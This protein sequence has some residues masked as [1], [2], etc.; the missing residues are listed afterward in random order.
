MI[1]RHGKSRSEKTEHP[2]TSDNCTERAGK[3]KWFDSHA[4]YKTLHENWFCH[5]TLCDDFFRGYQLK[6]LVAELKLLS[7]V[8][9]L[10]NNCNHWLRQNYHHRERLQQGL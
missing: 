4:R 10:F 7:Y 6:Y 5:K 3:R 9:H 8:F 2:E 1:D